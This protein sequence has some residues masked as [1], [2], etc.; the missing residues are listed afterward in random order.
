[1]YLISLN[2]EPETPKPKLNPKPPK[3]PETLSPKPKKPYNSPEDDEDLG[4]RAAPWSWRPPARQA[5]AD[6][7]GL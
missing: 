7:Q 5:G 1:M 4:R 3:P 6:F 2:P